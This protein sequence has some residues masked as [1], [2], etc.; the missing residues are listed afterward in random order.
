MGTEEKLLV[1][2]ERKKTDG[3]QKRYLRKGMALSILL[4]HTDTVAQQSKMNFAQV[5]SHKQR[6]SIPRIDA[7]EA[8]QQRKMP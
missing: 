3:I 1:E 2:E 4:F 5:V 8:V 7:G 6:L